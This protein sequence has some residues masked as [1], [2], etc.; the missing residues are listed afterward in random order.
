MGPG[1]FPIVLSVLLV[2]LGVLICVRSF[3]VPASPNAA[4]SLRGLV[5]ILL[6]PIF[7]GLTVRGLGFAP[8]VAGTVLLSATASRRMSVRQAALIATALTGVCIAIFH[9]AI[10]IP[11][12]LI[13]P[14]LRP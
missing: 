3:G 11:V 5:L 6:A 12:E 7:F 4:P 14:W 10:G 1:F 9:Y 2:A 13:G 8:A